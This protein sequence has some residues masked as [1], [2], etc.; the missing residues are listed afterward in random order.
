M[1]AMTRGAPGTKW[2][3]AREAAQQSL[4]AVLEWAVWPQAP[5]AVPEY[6]PAFWFPGGCC[7]KDQDLGAETADIRAPP[8]LEARSQVRVLQGW[9]ILRGSDPC[10]PSTSFGGHWQPVAC[11]GV[12]LSSPPS[13]HGLLWDPVSQCP[14]SIGLVP[15]YS[16]MTSP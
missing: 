12:T 11:R 6:Q 2:V 3:G 8:V 4:R 5:T 16:C 7:D 9:L 15:L 14:L 13:S 10:S 1:V